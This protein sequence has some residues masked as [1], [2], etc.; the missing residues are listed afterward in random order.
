MWSATHGRR[1]LPCQPLCVSLF[2][3][4]VTINGAVLLA[5]AFVLVFSPATVSASVAAPRWRCSGP[6]SWSSWR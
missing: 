6:A 1:A 3:R 5:A 2:W 4:V